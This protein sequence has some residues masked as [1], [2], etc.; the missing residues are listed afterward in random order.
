M[1]S[2]H[3]DPS[4]QDYP[5]QFVGNRQTGLAQLNNAVFPNQ[6]YRIV[7][8]IQT[9]ICTQ[10]IR[11]ENTTEISAEIT[12]QNKEAEAEEESAV[13][14]ALHFRNKIVTD[15]A[16]IRC[17]IIRRQPPGVYRH[18]CTRN[19]VTVTLQKDFHTL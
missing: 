3:A 17:T 4:A 10:R 13:T 9:L 12:P 7:P 2:A 11:T 15:H 8:F 16:A 6:V 5:I 19:Q 14:T 18:A 1:F